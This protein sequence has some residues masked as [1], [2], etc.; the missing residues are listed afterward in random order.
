MI[1]FLEQL[2]AR[3]SLKAQM[4]GR[5]SRIERCYW[6]TN[7]IMFAEETEYLVINQ[8]V[9]LCAFLQMID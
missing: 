3:V 7:A 2:V 8:P 6:F 9:R 4:L 1:R 5:T